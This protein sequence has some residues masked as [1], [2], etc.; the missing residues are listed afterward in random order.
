MANL[1]KCKSINQ[2][3]GR[4]PQKATPSLVSLR[5]ISTCSNHTGKLKTDIEP[6]TDAFWK[7][8]CSQVHVQLLSHFGPQN[9]GLDS[10]LF[11]RNILHPQRFTQLGLRGWVSYSRFI[12]LMEKILRHLLE[13]HVNSGILTI[14]TGT[15]EPSTV[16]LWSFR[17]FFFA[18]WFSGEGR[19]TPPPWR[20]SMATVRACHPLHP[21]DRHPCDLLV[22]HHFRS[23]GVSLPRPGSFRPSFADGFAMFFPTMQLWNPSFGMLI[24]R[25]Q[26]VMVSDGRWVCPSIPGG[27]S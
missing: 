15:S 2:I 12:P 3:K 25:A 14:S 18:S 23:Q 16:L 22:Q 27:C 26:Q 20:P 5:K 4:L 17:S 10:S 24:Q 8:E 19:S 13:N 6:E 21:C 7:T 11:L 1:L 9:K